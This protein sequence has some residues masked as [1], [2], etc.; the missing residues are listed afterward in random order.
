LHSKQKKDKKEEPTP[1][2]RLPIDVSKLDNEEMALII[3]SF[4]QILKQKKGKQYKPCSK[5]ICYW[6]GK[7]GHYIA[8]YPYACDSD[9]DDGEKG[10]KKMEK[11]K[12][13]NKKKGG[14]AHI[15]RE[16]DSD[17][18][19]TDSSSDK[20][21][22][23]IAIN[24]GLL[25]P[26]VGHK[27]LMAKEGKNK[28]VYSRD[29][30]KYTTSDDEGSSS[31][32]NDDLSSLFANLTIEQKEKIN[33]LI[34]TIN[35]KDEILECQEDLLVMENKKFVKLK[36]A[37]ALEVEK[38]KNLTKELNTS[39][40]SISCLKTENGSLIAKIEELNAC[41]VSTSTIEHVTVCTRCRDI[42]VNDVNDQLAMIKEQND[43]IAKLNAKIVEH[44]LEN[45]NFKFAHSMLYNR[46]RPGIKD[47]IG[48]QPGS[49]NNIKLNAHRNNISNF[50]KGKAPMVQDREGYILYPKNYPK[51][52]IRKNQAKKSH[53]VAHHAYIYRNEASSS[54]YTTHL[55]MPKKK[56]VDASNEHSIS[57]KTF[58]ASFVLTNKSGKVVAKYVGGKHKSPKTCVWVPESRLEGVNRRNMKFTTLNTHYKSGLALELKSNQAN[59]HGDLFY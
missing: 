30:P 2:N 9:R 40:D 36:D 47:G 22:V 37:F 49:Q 35:E 41:H 59:E 5:R 24:K 42:D 26:N 54:R 23:N 15:G 16:W 6:C 20:D 39:N 4:R 19:S 14:E 12:Y 57:F 38:C 34:K 3:K 7:S 21:V 33:E 29:I 53:L 44:E 25:F 55:K 52:K 50:V 10:K 31:E 17:E 48:F 32:K 13:Y 11:K 1:T 58:D 51:N 8:K 46:R 45:E 43:H 28:K 18:S 56:I 27:C